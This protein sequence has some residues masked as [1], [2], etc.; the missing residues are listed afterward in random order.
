METKTQPRTLTPYQL[1]G[2]E[3]K[4]NGLKGES[5]LTSFFSKNKEQR[6]SSLFR[7]IKRFTYSS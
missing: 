7:L 5:P 2:Y 1:A 4:T 3:T 6:N